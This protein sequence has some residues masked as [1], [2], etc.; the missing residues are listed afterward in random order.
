MYRVIYIS[1]VKKS[2]MAKKNKRIKLTFLKKNG[3][4]FSK[5]FK[6][7]TSAKRALLGWRAAGGRMAGKMRS[8]KAKGYAKS[9]RDTYRSSISR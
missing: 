8:P 9:A 5:R 4:T 1:E 7:L 2:V 3:K 6:S